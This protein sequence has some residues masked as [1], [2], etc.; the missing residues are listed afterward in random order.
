MMG[1]LRF[2]SRSDELEEDTAYSLVT[3]PCRC[4][5][6]IEQPEES[7]SDSLD[8]EQPQA[9]TPTTNIVTLSRSEPTCIYHTLDTT[10][11]FMMNSSSS[12]Y[13]D[14]INNS[15]ALN[16]CSTQHLCPY[17]HE[18][19]F[20]SSSKHEGLAECDSLENGQVF[21][22]ESNAARKLWMTSEFPIKDW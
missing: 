13:F 15:E 9:F 2:E 14:S 16:D 3:K 6:T 21:S 19:G 7:F 12:E 10:G 11:T 1:R 22:N 5:N 8:L 17:Y 20:H 4:E 18:Q